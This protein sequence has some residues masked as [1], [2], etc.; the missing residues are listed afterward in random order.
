MVDFSMLAQCQKC[1]R[2]LSFRS[3]RESS[4]K[5]IVVNPAFSVGAQPDQLQG[6][7][8]KKKRKRIGE[9]AS[10]SLTAAC[11]ECTYTDAERAPA[12]ANPN[13]VRPLYPQLTPK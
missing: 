1:C 10:F 4:N 12:F 6:D 9:P 11:T 5:V 2:I 7:K 13:K 3:V 8:I